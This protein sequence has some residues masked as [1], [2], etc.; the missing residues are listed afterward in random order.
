[1]KLYFTEEVVK[2]DKNIANEAILWESTVDVVLCYRP[3]VNPM[4][5][6]MIYLFFSYCSFLFIF[7]FPP[8]Q[9]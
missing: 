6:S 2:P 1:M 5:C 9:K 4:V 3:C 8:N 7:F